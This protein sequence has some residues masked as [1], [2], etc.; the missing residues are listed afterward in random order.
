MG[1]SIAARN[2]ESGS[3]VIAINFTGAASI[4][5][6]CANHLENARSGFIIGLPRLRAIADGKATTST[7]PR[8]AR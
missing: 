1:D 5:G 3:R 8:K 2:F 4:L 7:A 6:L